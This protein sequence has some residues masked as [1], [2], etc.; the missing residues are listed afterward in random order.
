MNFQRVVIQNQNDQ[1]HGN[2]CNK[3]SRFYIKVKDCV[4]S[5]K[6]REIKSPL[7][8]ANSFGRSVELIKSVQ[9]VNGIL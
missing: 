6:I 7:G 1:K 9:D 8:I 5:F 3:L 4:F 2:I